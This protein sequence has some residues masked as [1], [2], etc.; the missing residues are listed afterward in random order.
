[1]S[2]FASRPRALAAVLLGLAVVV[3]FLAGVAADRLLLLPRESVAAEARAGGRG[4]EFRPETG[5]RRAGERY[6]DMLA[7]E[8]QLSAEQRARIDTILSVQQQRIREVHAEARPRVQAI[9]R[10]TREAIRTVLTAEQRERFEQLRAQRGRLP[11]PHMP[12]PDT[13]P[14]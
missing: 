5:P 11:G 1:M 8:L 12:R 10:D 6:L 4:A 13:Q 7:E 14:R 9:T 2:T 3:G